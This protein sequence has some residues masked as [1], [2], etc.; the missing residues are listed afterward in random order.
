MMMEKGA[1]IG[2]VFLEPALSL[3]KMMLLARRAP[4]PHAAALFID[5]ALSRQGQNYVGMVIAMS[6]VRKGQKQKYMQLGNLNTKPITPSL[7]GLN[8]D[9][10]IKLYNKIFGLK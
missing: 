10:Y 6:P 8:Y 7:L 9:R 2:L 1:P 4:H 3:P 5:W